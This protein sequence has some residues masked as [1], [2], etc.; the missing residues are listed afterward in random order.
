MCL[1]DVF[2]YQRLSTYI[3]VGL[4]PLSP[5]L[6]IVSLLGIIILTSY[7]S[8]F[9]SSLFYCQFEFVVVVLLLL[10]VVYSSRLGLLFRFCRTFQ[11][12]PSSSNTLN[13]SSVIMVF[14]GFFVC[15]TLQ[16]LLLLVAPSPS[17]CCPRSR[18]YCSS[19]SCSL[20]R[21]YCCRCVL[22]HL[23]SWGLT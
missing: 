6:I 16:L 11:T 18:Q 21:W 17:G 1:A 5:I 4:H 22:T 23:P 10:F 14:F 15:P 3:S 20:L 9:Q 13:L 12:N 19:S 7:C 8:I 2:D